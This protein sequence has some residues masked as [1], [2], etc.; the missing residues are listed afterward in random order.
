MKSKKL[1][2]LLMAICMMTA[3]IVP[4]YAESFS[5]VT[6]SIGT[7]YLDAI[8]YMSDN[9]IICGWPD[10]TFR[11]E[12]ALNRGMAVTVLFRMSGDGG[13]YSASMFTDVSPSS[14]YYNA[15][16]WAYAKGI[17]NGTTATTFEPNTLVQRQQ[18][19]VMLYRFAGYKG[20]SQTVTEN[21]ASYTDYSSVG[22]FAKTGVSWAYS[23]AIPYN[24]TNSYTI[25][26]LGSVARKD[27]A[28][29]CLNY[30]HNVEGI[31]AGRDNYSFQNMAT[32]FVS[33]NAD[34]YLMSDSDWETFSTL[35]ESNPLLSGHT[36]ESLMN[37]KG[38]NGS[39]F[40]MATTLALDYSGIID[41]NGNFCNNA[42]TLYSIPRLSRTSSAMHQLTTTPACQG[43]R[44]ISEAES[45][46]NFYQL[47]QYF[48]PINEWI[49]QKNNPNSE[50]K[51]LV[52]GQEYGGIGVFSYRLTSGSG[53]AINVYGKPT[54]TENGYRVKI[55]DNRYNNTAGYIEIVVNNGVY[56]GTVV[57]FPYGSTAQ[58]ETIVACRYTSAFD[59]FYLYDFDIDGPFNKTSIVNQD[60]FKQKLNGYEIL[61]V[62]ADGDFSIIDDAGN[63]LLMRNG[64][65]T[66]T[67][68]VNRYNFIVFGENSPCEYLFVVPKSDS[69]RCVA[70]EG[71]L[72]LFYAIDNDGVTGASKYESDSPQ[73]NSVDINKTG[74]VEIN[75]ADGNRIS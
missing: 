53:H 52:S 56:S 44:V 69:Y 15:I 58:R 60:I 23:Y 70:N 59:N 73:L 43:S 47:S 40:G 50:L 75:R 27:M 68:G 13:T 74:N 8:N 14:D 21:M 67:I 10:G 5:D 25:N 45:K 28:V 63:T 29:F 64:E 38:W 3:L 49:V 7:H 9:E 12:V 41:L 18:L 35:E 61:R 37:A 55:Y 2:A 17:T 16:G 66:D 11:P 57:N 1:I 20:Y 24:G 54:T 31:V 39:C 19:M 26:P 51:K 34:R 42:S 32:H 33:G 36:V 48:V 65:F 46:I 4:A 30:R 62:K 6:T 72:D 22:N 71:N